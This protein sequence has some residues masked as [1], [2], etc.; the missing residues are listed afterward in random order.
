MCQRMHSVSLDMSW[1]MSCF[2][3][4]KITSKKRVTDAATSFESDNKNDQKHNVYRF[5]HIRVQ[6]KTPASQSASE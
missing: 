2:S 5:K 6:L 4:T 3:F 1:K